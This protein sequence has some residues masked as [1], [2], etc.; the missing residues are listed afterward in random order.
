MTNIDE[1]QYR[2]EWATKLHKSPSEI[3]VP[4]A[5]RDPEP[6]VP[7]VNPGPP[8]R[9]GVVTGTDP[10]EITWDEEVPGA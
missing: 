1:T 2:A 4:L 3:Y 8:P 9:H 10:V 7:S 6:S 5:L